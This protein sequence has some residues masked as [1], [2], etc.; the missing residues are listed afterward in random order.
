[1][2]FNI[3]KFVV[4]SLLCS[5]GVYLFDQKFNKPVIILQFTINALYIYIYV[6]CKQI[7]LYIKW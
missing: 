7:W 1:M 6:L 4:E 2:N 3:Q 5:Q